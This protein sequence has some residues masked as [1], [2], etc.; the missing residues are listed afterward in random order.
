VDVQATDGSLSTDLFDSSGDADDDA[1]PDTPD[2]Q[3]ELEQS[4]AELTAALLARTCTRCGASPCKMFGE[5]TA[6]CTWECWEAHAR[7][8]A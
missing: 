1:E 6:F 3:V 7:G 8:I 4:Q 5:G 2:R